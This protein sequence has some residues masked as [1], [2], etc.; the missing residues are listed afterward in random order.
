MRRVDLTPALREACKEVYGKCISNPDLNS[1]AFTAAARHRD[2][3]LRA[4]SLR[5]VRIED[6]GQGRRVQN[7]VQP[8]VKKKKENVII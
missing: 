5:D 2:P 1:G 4:A 3:A 8:C 6:S 7:R